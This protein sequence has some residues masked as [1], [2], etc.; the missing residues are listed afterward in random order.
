[1]KKIKLI[2]MLA[3]MGV[4]TMGLSGLALAD[5]PAADFYKTASKAKKGINY[6]AYLYARGQRGE[7]IYKKFIKPA[8]GYNFTERADMASH[9]YVPEW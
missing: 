4:M 5:A 1:M 2:C 8:K 6:P 7:A 3:V 9:S